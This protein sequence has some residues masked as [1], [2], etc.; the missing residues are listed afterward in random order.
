VAQFRK[1][2]LRPKPYN[3]DMTICVQRCVDPEIFESPRQS[4]DFTKNQQLFS[5][6]PQQ[7]KYWIRVHLRLH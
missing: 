6:R 2:K 1:K 3:N 5:P 4:A 7:E